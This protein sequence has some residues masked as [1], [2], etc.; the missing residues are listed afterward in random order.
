MT[1]PIK[2]LTV[3]QNWDCQACSTCCREYTIHITEEERQRILAQKWEESKELAGVKLITKSGRWWN[4]WWSGRWTLN[5]REDHACVFLNEKGYCRI[6]DKFG[7]AGK[8]L[9]CR[10]Y[11]FMLIPGGDHWKIGLRYACPSAVKNLGRELNDHDKDLREYAAQLEVREAI[12]YRKILAPPLQG[13]E[14]LSWGDLDCFIRALRRII[15]TQT[16]PV[17]WRLRKC[18][19]FCN[20]CQGI[21]FS[22]MS[23]E[24]L[25][26]FL[27]LMVDHI[28]PEIPPAEQVPAPGWIGRLLFRQLSA[29]YGRKDT[30]V[31]RGISRYG[32]LAL[33]WAAWKVARGKGRIP[34]L[35]AWMP[36]TTYQDAE[37]PRG[38]L[39]P[40]IDSLLMRYYLVKLEST[41][42][43]GPTNFKAKFWD[44]L[45]SL[46]MTYPAILWL[47]RVFCDRPR[48]EAIS[49]ALRVVDDNFGFNK[50]LGNRRQRFAIRILSM[51]GELA[52][53]VAWYSR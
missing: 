28:S 14:Q 3:L 15:G 10:V 1:L 40:E 53:L 38:K 48:A 45:E 25:K 26:D 30:G 24:K 34:R 29:F 31:H 7:S 4:R 27:F 51:R 49:L 16:E 12:H 41:Q 35:H 21:D 46:I 33:V 5:H 13:K 43:C 6:H 8:P 18:L 32:R 42:F 23:G 47:S 9:A 36:Y 37:K 20:L 52:K 19:L 17:E 11:P 2:T 50:Y 44:G 39:P 22:A